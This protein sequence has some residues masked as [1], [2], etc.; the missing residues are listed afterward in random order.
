MNATA[1]NDRTTR[2]NAL[3]AARSIRVA[4]REGHGYLLWSSVVPRSVGDPFSLPAY[5]NYS[6]NRTLVAL[7]AVAILVGVAMSTEWMPGDGERV[8]LTPVA[9]VGLRLDTLLIGGYAG[10]SFID[11]VGVVAGGLKEEERLLVGRHLDRIFAGILAESGLGRTGRLRLAYERARRPDGSTRSIRVLGAE[12][13]ASGRV[14]TAF[15]FERDGR[16]GYYDP[17]GRSLDTQNT[18]SPLRAMRVSSPFGDRRLHPIL[19]RVLPHTGVDLAA[20]SG[21][22]VR[23]TSD[24]IV[25]RA[26]HGGGYGLLIELQHP[27]GYGSR[28]AHLSRLASGIEPMQLVRQG[29]LIGYV[30]MTG[31]ATGPHLH[32]EI[33]RRGQPIDPMMASANSALGEQLGSDRRWSSERREL[34]TLLARTPTVVQTAGMSGSP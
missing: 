34:A 14:H 9:A 31:L 5:R 18:T 12:V 27:D 7:I 13:A 22:P 17:L 29:D 32:Y 23:A 15:Y 3:P 21:E 25:T 33:R 6:V 24:G 19:N 26:G 28:Y 11:A 30:G 1:C 10:G 20:P 8:R 16:P 4:A 2:A